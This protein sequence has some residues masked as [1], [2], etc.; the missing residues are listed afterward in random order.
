MAWFLLP[1]EGRILA[2]VLQSMDLGLRIDQNQADEKTMAEFFE[3]VTLMVQDRTQE[4]KEVNQ[5]VQENIR[6][7]VEN[8]TSNATN[9]IQTF[10]A[11]GV[12]TIKGLDSNNQ[13]VIDLMT[14]KVKDTAK[15]WDGKV[16]ELKAFDIEAYNIKM[17]KVE[18]IIKAF[19]KLL[20]D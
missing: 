3:K 7:N 14:K 12:D 9:E 17:K 15:K 5:G 1:D 10:V 20:E 6:Q 2:R 4:M 19:D 11:T 8:M 13:S 16:D 18:D